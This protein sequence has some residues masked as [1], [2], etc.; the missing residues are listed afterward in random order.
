MEKTRLRRAGAFPQQ[1]HGYPKYE[2]ENDER[3]SKMRGKPVLAHIHPLGEAT[4][5][6]V[7]A[8]RPLKTA[9]NEHQHQFR[10]QFRAQGFREIEV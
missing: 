9:E 4:G 7:P 1:V 10:Q 3:E 6:H 2:S 5:D 8:Q